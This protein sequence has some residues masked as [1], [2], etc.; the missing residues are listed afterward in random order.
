MIILRPAVPNDIQA[1][2]AVVKSAFYSEAKNEVFN[3]W[4]F[5]EKVTQDSGYVP[6]LCL[7]AVLEDKIVGY[8][9]LSK[10]K[11]GIHH[12]LALGPIAVEP[13]LQSLGIGKKLVTQ[14]L[15]QAKNLGYD[16]VALTGGDYYLKFGF[17]PTAQFGIIL[18]ENHPENTYLKICFLEE[19]LK[20]TLSGSMQFCDSFYNEKGDLL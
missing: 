3:E 6:E 11:I 12:G 18:S 20:N 7:L 16:W 17:V 4:E 13:N 19:T 1:I 15:E 2:K 10:A 8:V 5:V 9:L 14:S